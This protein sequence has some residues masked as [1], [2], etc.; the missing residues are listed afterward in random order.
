M[1]PRVTVLMPVYNGEKHLREAI[2][3]ILNQTFR[4]FELLIINDGSNDNSEKIILSYSDQRIRLINQENNGLSNSLN[5]GINLSNG[6]FVARMDQD[7]ISLNNRLEEQI[8]FM[9]AN[10]DVGIC[11]AYAI[12]INEKGDGVGRAVYPLKHEDIRAQ[13]LFSS[14]IVHP[15]AIFRKSIFINNNLEYLSGKSE[16]YDLWYR[17]GNVTRLANINKFLFKY[18]ADSGYSNVLQKQAYLSSAHQIIKNNILELDYFSESEINIYRNMY[19]SDYIPDRKFLDNSFLLLNKIRQSNYVSRIYNI[20]SL[21]L[22]III[23]WFYICIRI[24][25]KKYIFSLEFWRYSI[26]FFFRLKIRKKIS[27]IK[28]I[29]AKLFGKI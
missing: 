28:I 19:D 18:R 21:D 22:V 16:D 26:I 7:D 3:S 12:I 25:K 6:E 2:E 9:D 15:S 1:T 11:G 29:Q 10:P 20:E 24:E 23:K 27:L 8:K 14:S 17:A 4:D 5:K 13:L